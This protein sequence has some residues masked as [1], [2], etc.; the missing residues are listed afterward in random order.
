MNTKLIIFKD[1]Y[2]QAKHKNSVKYAFTFSLTY[3]FNFK[4]LLHNTKRIFISIDIYSP[5]KMVQYF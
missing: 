1:L 4:H 3:V 2:R 5:N